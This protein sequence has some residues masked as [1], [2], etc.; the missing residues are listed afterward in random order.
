MELHDFHPAIH[1]LQK[2][3]SSARKTRSIIAVLLFLLLF[4]IFVIIYINTTSGL[5]KGMSDFYKTFSDNK[6]FD[7]RVDGLNSSLL[8]LTK[9]FDSAKSPEALKAQKASSEE[10]ENMVK[11]V[12]VNTKIIESYAKWKDVNYRLRGGGNQ[13]IINSVTTSV[14]TIAFSICSILLLIF[15][16]TNICNVYEILCTT[17][18]AL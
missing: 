12:D 6:V 3:A 17:C 14:A 9:S 18:R 15:F 16:G 1:N 7:N 13:N 4:V 5:A 8:E 2:R 11:N 10:F